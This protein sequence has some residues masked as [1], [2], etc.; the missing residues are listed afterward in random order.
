MYAQLRR[1]VDLLLHRAFSTRWKTMGRQAWFYDIDPL[2]TTKSKFDEQNSM[3]KA[4]QLFVKGEQG[5]F[6]SNATSSCKAAVHL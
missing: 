1:A 4:L 5:S 3:V 2:D 6:F